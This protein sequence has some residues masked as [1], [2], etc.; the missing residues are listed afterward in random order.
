MTWRDTGDWLR[1]HAWVLKSWLIGGLGAA[2][3][4][5]LVWTLA[6]RNNLPTF[7]A[8]LAGLLVGSSV[9]FVANR[10]LVFRDARQSQVGTQAARFAALMAGLFLAHAFTVAFARDTIGVPLLLAKMGADLLYFGPGYPFL[11]RWLVFGR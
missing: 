10:L 5:A 3:D 7:A 2:V 6:G 1:A 8:A 9:N 11:L 4:Y